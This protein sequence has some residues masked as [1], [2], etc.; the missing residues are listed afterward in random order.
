[1]AYTA[2]I[3]RTN[4][5][6]FL[7]LIDQSGSMSD[8][9]VATQKPKS[10]AVAD[11]IN[12]LLQQLVIKCAKSEGVRDYYHIGVIGYNADGVKPAFTG[13]IAGKELVPISEIAKTPARVEERNKK[14]DDGAG[15]LITT[16]IKFPIW[17]DAINNGGTPMKE[18]FQKANGI[19][20]SWLADHPDCFP[21]VVINITDGESTDGSP[22][23]EMDKLKGK[24]SSDGSVILFN[25]HASARANNIISFCG[26]STTLPDQYAEMLFQGASP[27]PE[28]MMT[29]GKQEY[30]LNLAEDARAFVLNADPELLITA[31]DIGTRPS[32]ALALR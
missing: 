12:K 32:N 11:A 26:S 3:S 27:L 19:I 13:A 30:G 8:N 18:A 10:Q 23:E 28:F 16:T 15:G 21:P 17:F 1:M 14:I 6:C 2:E 24:A 25:I 9:F 5:S 31:I 29:V 4:P 20:D 22:I 7:F